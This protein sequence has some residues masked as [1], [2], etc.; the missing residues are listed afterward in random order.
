MKSSHLRTVIAQVGGGIAMKL[1]M[2]STFPLVGFGWKGE[3]LEKSYRC[4]V[5]KP[6]RRFYGSVERRQDQ[7][8]KVVRICWERGPLRK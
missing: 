8:V 3:R 2:L 4:L 1:S 7:I 5:M 6:E